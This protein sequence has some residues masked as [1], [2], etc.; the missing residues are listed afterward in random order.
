ML[1]FFL[2]FY[3]RLTQLSGKL[4]RLA[5]HPVSNFVVARAIA[6]LDEKKLTMAL[7]ELE[8]TWPKFV[9]ALIHFSLFFVD[10]DVNT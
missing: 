1:M 5:V 8:G 10:N 9:S 6:R 3:S 4:T 7:V 2:W